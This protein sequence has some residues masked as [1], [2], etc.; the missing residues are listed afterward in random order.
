MRASLFWMCLYM[1]T[2]FSMAGGSATFGRHLDRPEVAAK[3]LVAAWIDESQSFA[4]LYRKLEKDFV[5]FGRS[6]R[7]VR[8]IFFRSHA[9]IFHEYQQYTLESDV[10]REGLYDCVSGSLILAALLE[11]FGFSYEAI[12]TSYHV[13]LQVSVNG[14]VLLLEV[15]DPRYGFITETEELQHYLESYVTTDSG[16]L[17]WEPIDGSASLPEV[18]QPIAL[19]ELLGL[20]YY[21]QAVRYLNN[22]NPLAAYQFSA[23]ALKYYDSERIHAL[24]DF[25]RKELAKFNS[26]NG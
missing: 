1:V 10:L 6:E 18:Y 25:L 19:R 2:V 26:I 4:N 12:E 8:A 9:V 15:T 23:T 24:S 16:S 22:G 17:F 21:N 3:S 5:R 20:Q 14:E 13:F 7:M 11:A